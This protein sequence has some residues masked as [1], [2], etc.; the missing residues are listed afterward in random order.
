MPPVD[1]NYIGCTNSKSALTKHLFR[2][3]YKAYDHLYQRMQ[4]KR[5]LGYAFYFWISD[6]R[7]VFC[8]GGGGRTHIVNEDIKRFH[9]ACET[10][11]RVL[12]T[13]E[14]DANDKIMMDHVVKTGNYLAITADLIDQ[15]AK[16]RELK[17]DFLIDLGKR[18]ARDSDIAAAGGNGGIAAGGGNGGQRD[19]IELDSDLRSLSLLA[20]DTCNTHA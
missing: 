20:Q 13:M 2:D 17:S 7:N 11:V 1:L 16:F 19:V 8:D 18:K 9:S 4:L 6:S 14:L 5:D 3:F 10:M 12:E 15:D